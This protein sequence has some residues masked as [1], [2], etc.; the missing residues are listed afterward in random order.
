MSAL[1][2]D[3][4]ML[5]LLFG[6]AMLLTALILIFMLL[7]AL[8]GDQKRF[9]RRLA[10]IGQGLSAAEAPI[11]TGPTL[12]RETADSSI[13]GL[14]SLIKRFLP[15]P[16]KLRDRL[17]ATGRKISLGEYVL[18]NLFVGIAAFALIHLFSGL[19]ILVS[20]ILAVGDGVGLPYFFVGYLGKRRR[21]RFILL[22]PE[23]IDLIVRGLRSGL[24][25]TE[26]I[27]VVGQE[28][29]DPVGVEFRRIIESFS[30]GMTLEQALWGASGRIGIA[31][32]R[33]FVIS[34]AV[35]QETG[36]NLTETL[37]NL[38]NI[39][40]RR[41]QMKLK[42]RALTG[43]ARASA[44][45]L[46]ALPFLSFAALMVTSPTYAD[47]LLSTRA[48]HWLLVT[49]FLLMSTGIGIMIRMTKFEI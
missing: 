37:D 44:G 36:G 46:A 39:L 25:I 5:P 33:F 21:N 43:E 18:A 26:S 34:L 28:I 35:Q 22:L 15:Q 32:F 14:D 29:P 13:R 16:A 7:G 3:D 41:K 4:N 42:I 6:G 38:G 48:G 20:G 47:V 8:T 27:R 12:R 23:A 40:R 49:G 11:G 17:A 45:I 1:F 9:R 10:R 30:I 2:T 24:P 31:E 19:P